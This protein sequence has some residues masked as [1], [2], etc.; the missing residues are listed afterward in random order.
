MTK[1]I[2]NKNSNPSN[3]TSNDQLDMAIRI[4]TSKSW[5]IWTVITCVFISLILWS[6]LGAVYIRVQGKG[7]ILPEPAVIFG[8]ESQG[9]G[10][11]ISLN[12]KIGDR[13]KKDEVLAVLD[14]K[15][16]QK[17]I[18][19]TNK[20]IAKLKAQGMKITDKIG[21]Q[22][23]YLDH[24]TKKF[25][26]ALDVQKANSEKYKTFMIKYVANE[27]EIQKDGAISM[28][29]TEKAIDALFKIENNL[30]LIISKKASHKLDQ[31]RYRFEW[32]KENLDIDL[33]ILKAENK[34]AEQQVKLEMSQVVRSPISG[35]V[36]QITARPGTYLK[37]GFP[38]VT[39][40]EDSK[41]DDVLGFF[42]LC[43]GKRID[44][45]MLAFVS[46]T[47]A[48]K[49]LY[50]TIRSRV[51][52]VS[53]YPLDLKTL[54][55]I[56]KEPDLAKYFSKKGPPLMCKLSL[57]RDK[58]TFSG[59]EWTSHKGPHYKITNGTLCDIYIVVEKRRPITL[60]IPFLRKL[61][62]LSYE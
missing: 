21:K 9:S 62:G 8:A 37:P 3:N 10:L 1:Q 13:V 35:R 55:S 51:E 54:I 17:Q 25:N 39:I 32:L 46:P 19:E 60:V 41:F 6:I 24:Y 40:V 45:K 61:I 33:Q 56:L 23:I 7:I 12:V 5:F 18:N 34:L 48:K 53:E 15:E 14:V 44:K 30:F 2:F 43:E 11:L 4:K 36:N 29:T 42:Y 16:Q 49:E 57:G 38:V 20:Y 50:G 52:T 31:E 28:M 27:K 22:E 47:T 59:F 26:Q 58:N